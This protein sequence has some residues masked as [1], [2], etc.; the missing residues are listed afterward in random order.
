MVK[1][2][3]IPPGQRFRILDRDD[4]TCF[5]CGRSAPAVTLE[6]DHILAI[7]DGGDNDDDNLVAACR[8]CNIGKSKSRV[9]LG[10]FG[11]GLHMLFRITWDDGSITHKHRFDLTIRD[12]RQLV[13]MEERKASAHHSQARHYQADIDMMTAHDLGEDE[14]YEY[15]LSVTPAEAG[16]SS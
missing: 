12:Y 9:P 1:R 5:W 4:Y 15:D 7:A 11:G 14:P 10:R 8:D 13:V 6:V 16:L 3:G 2:R